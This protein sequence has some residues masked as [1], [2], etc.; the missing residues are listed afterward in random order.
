MTSNTR[1]RKHFDDVTPT[2]IQIDD[3]QDRYSF[4]KYVREH[5]SSLRTFGDSCKFRYDSSQEHTSN[6]IYPVDGTFHVV[7]DSIVFILVLEEKVMNDFLLNPF[8]NIG[9]T[10]ITYGKFEIHTNNHEEVR[11]L[12]QRALTWEKECES[13]KIRVCLQSDGYWD[14]YSDQ[15]CIGIENL[16]IPGIV[17]QI[18]EKLDKFISLKDKYFE[19]GIPYKHTI[20][21]Q[22]KPGMGKTS[23]IKSIAKKYRRKM[24]VLSLSDESLNECKLRRLI[25]SIPEKSVLV[26]EDLDTFF[27]GRDVLQ[28]SRISFSTL[29]N[30]LDGNLSNTKGL[31]TFITA[32]RIQDFDSALIRPGR[33]DSIF[34]FGDM[35]FEQFSQAC[36]KHI[37]EVDEQLFRICQRNQISMSGLMYVLFYGESQEHRRQLAV[38]IEKDRRQDNLTYFT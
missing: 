30:V 13:S 36:T 3:F 11:N 22:G 7:V 9:T 20:L 25:T 28:G 2:I 17:D 12:I 31:I 21:L 33:I 34:H 10:L 8:A 15:A 37:Q 14:D 35:T 32:N 38:D 6:H 27:K 5:A 19:F 1:K 26:L 4:L 24:H 16:F 23:L 18:I 29:L